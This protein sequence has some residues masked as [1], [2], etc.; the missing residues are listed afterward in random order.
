MREKDKDKAKGTKPASFSSLSGNSKLSKEIKQLE[1]MDLSP[2]QFFEFLNWWKEWEQ[3][4]E[5]THQCIWPTELIYDTGQTKA[6][7][8]AEAGIDGSKSLRKK[9][10]GLGLKKKGLGTGRSVELI[11]PPDYE[12]I[13]RIRKEVAAAAAAAAEDKKRKG[14]H[15]SIEV[16]SHVCNLTETQFRCCSSC[17]CSGSTEE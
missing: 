12:Y 14:E 11:L 3:G 2:Q 7:S 10:K 16:R 15:G 1:E 6:R 8:A 5:K 4:R 9:G 17:R 13:Q